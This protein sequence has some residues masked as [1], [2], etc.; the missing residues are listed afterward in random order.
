MNTSKALQS[1]FL[2]MIFSIT[3]MGMT[4]AQSALVDKGYAPV[5]GLQMY[6][7]IHGQGE[8]LVILHGAYMTIEGPIREMATKLSKNR[9]VIAVEMQGHGRTADINRQITSE[10]LAGDVAELLN[11]LNIE[12]ADVLGYSM[13]GG[14]A[15]H[16][17]VSHP[18]KIR[19]LVIASAT[20]NSD[21]VYPQL[22][23]MIPHMTADVFDNTP[24]RDAYDSIAPNPEDFPNLVSKLK[25]LDNIIVNLKAEDLKA[26]NLPA[27]IILGDSDM[28]IPEHAVEMFR[29]FGGGVMGDLAGLP[30][31]Q[32]AVLPGTTHVGVMERLD[33]IIP[34]VDDFLGDRMTTS[35]QE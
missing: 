33:L 12:K 26:V 35:V 5:N 25:Q 17:A 13:G 15:L 29:L 14:V 8:P 18:D 24:I 7:E 23:E 6:Y 22:M 4:T 30:Q 34:M 3:T 10:L 20:F 1:I 32:L 31:S 27:L 2:V 19:K 16:L 11:Y 21:G 9:Q 28:T